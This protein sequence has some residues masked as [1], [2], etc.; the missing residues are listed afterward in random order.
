MAQTYVTTGSFQTVRVLSQNQVLDVQAI[1]IAT[2]P[3]GCRLTVPV[4]LAAYHADEWKPYL[5]IVSELIES[6]I[7]ATPDPGQQLVSGA[8][9]SQQIDGAGLLAYFVN[10]TVA[11]VPTSGQAGTF[12][13]IVTLPVSSFESAEAFNTPVD[14]VV[15]L[16]QIEHAYARLKA[17]AN[18]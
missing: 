6:L 1:G 7:A 9:G 4:P 12:S 2:K 17:T 8:A 13:T 15:P 3:S 10:F 14:G 18:A 5:E 16:L 11:Y